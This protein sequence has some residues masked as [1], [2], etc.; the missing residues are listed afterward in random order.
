MD[1]LSFSKETNLPI[2]DFFII[3]FNLLLAVLFITAISILMNLIFITVI[4]FSFVTFI[5]EYQIFYV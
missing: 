4:K 3:A 2:N 5:L 1:E